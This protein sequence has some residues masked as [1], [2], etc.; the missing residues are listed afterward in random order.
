MFKISC[1]NTQAQAQKNTHTQKKTH[2]T[3]KHTCAH[4]HA[5]GSGHRGRWL[6]L[7]RQ[8]AAALARHPCGGDGAVCV[9]V[10]G[11][12][13]R[14]AHLSPDA[15]SG[16]HLHQVRGAWC[17]GIHTHSH[18]CARRHTLAHAGKMQWGLCKFQWG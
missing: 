2:D 13:A 16:P 15:P 10:R 1:T 14:G 6:H 9:Q 17:A 7:V 11:R 4:A 8:P 18:R 3:R 5:H 12:S